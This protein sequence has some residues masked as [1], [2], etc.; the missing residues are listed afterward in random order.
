MRDQL[1]V[2][3][4]YM[5]GAMLGLLGLGWEQILAWMWSVAPLSLVE[6]LQFGLLYAGCGALFYGTLS[7][8]VDNMAVRWWTFWGG[9]TAVLVASKAWVWKVSLLGILGFGATSALIGT[10]VLLVMEHRLFRRWPGSVWPL[11]CVGFLAL[12]ALFFLNLNVLGAV[13]SP[14]ALWTDAGIALAGLLLLFGLTV[15]PMA[16]WRRLETRYVAIPVGLLWLGIGTGWLKEPSTVVVSSSDRQGPPVVLIVVD[17][18]RADH[19]GFMGYEHATSPRLDSFA[20]SALSF[21]Q[22]QSAAPWTLPSFGSLL[23]GVVPSVHGAGV[24]LGQ[25]NTESQLGATETTL[26]EMFSKAGYGTAAVVSNTYLKRAYGLD[27]GFDHYDDVVTMGHLPLLFQPLSMVLGPYWMGRPYR[28][29]EQMG[30]AAH[31]VMRQYGG[32]PYFLLLHFMDPHDPYFPQ[33]DDVTVL[34]AVSDEYRLYD[35]EIRG[36]DRAVGTVLDALPEDAIVIVTSD[37]GEMFGEHEGAYSDWHPPHSRHGMTQYQELLHVPLLIRAPELGAQSVLRPVSLVDL[38][39]NIA[40]IAGEEWTGGGELWPELHA[41]SVRTGQP[42]VSEAIRYGRERKAVRLG[43]WKAIY[44]PDKE[45]LYYLKT[46][47]QEQKNVR[48][49][50][51]DIAEGLRIFVP[52]APQDRPV[53]ADPSNAEREA[54][55]QLGYVDE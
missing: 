43:D 15:S 44:G 23:T 47:P 46:D 22:A 27:R 42:A 37:H 13:R 18:L 35:A 54:L 20:N 3:R 25:G 39:A 21:R 6:C 24:N 9:C 16:Y 45:E 51:P 34:T 10:L 28:S 41:R 19:L 12:W 55:R 32:A 30:D 17:T 5:I 36:V 48:A 53:A 52:D 1:D 49:L 50:F 29:A 11:R 4:Q 14:E 2:M 31:A 40:R 33:A 7:V 8:I 26:A 38:A